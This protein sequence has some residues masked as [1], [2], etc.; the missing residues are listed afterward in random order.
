MADRLY[1]RTLY[2]PDS[3]Q[4]HPLLAAALT[5]APF[6]SPMDDAA[7]QTHCF[8]PE[9]PVIHSAR[10]LHRQLTGAMI[11][12][13]LMG[14]IDVAVGYDHATQHLVGDRP[15]GLLRFLALPQDFTLSGEIARLLLKGAEEFWWGHGVRRVRAFSYSTG[16]PPFQLAAGL[17]PSTWEDHHRWLNQAGYRP[18]ERYYCLTYPLKRMGRE[19]VPAGR[20]TLFPESDESGVNFQV[21]ENDEVRMAATRMVERQ[22]LQPRDANPVAG[23]IELIVA[24]AWR[25]RGV[26]RWLL[27]RMINDALLRGNRT[28]ALFLN[29]TNQAGLGL[30]RQ[31]GFE[32]MNYRGYTL[33]KQL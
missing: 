6:S 26:G 11:E 24:S 19:D 16:Y 17:M 25:R 9:P 27:R 4:M 10:W 29:H 28:L 14:F 2:P 33:E 18:T 13:R 8:L 31:I 21:Y 15:I 1:T 12:E 30:C 32:E 5:K 20:F 3:H 22:V 23:V 7:I